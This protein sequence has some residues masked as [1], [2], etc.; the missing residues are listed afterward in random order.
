MG[1]SSSRS[2][3][4]QREIELLRDA[5]LNT[6]DEERIA[7]LIDE[8]RFKRDDPCYLATIGGAIKKTLCCILWSGICFVFCLKTCPNVLEFIIAPLYLIGKWLA[9]NA[10]TPLVHYFNSGQAEQP[11]AIKADFFPEAIELVNTN[12]SF[13]HR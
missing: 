1:N 7:D 2:E 5:R 8:E 10:I 9:D 3:K 13:R 11:A 4:I 6:E 12:P